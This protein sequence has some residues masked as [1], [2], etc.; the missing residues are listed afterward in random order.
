[1]TMARH[2]DVEPLISSWVRSLRADGKSPRTIESYASA[3]RDFTGWCVDNG[4]PVLP[5]RQRRGDVEDYVGHLIADRSAGT[6]GVR[7]RSLRQWFRWLVAEDEADDVMAGMRHPKLSTKVVPVIADDDLRALL[8]VTKGRELLDRRD[9]AIFR[10][11]IDTGM[12]RG[13]L[14][15]LTVG[16]VDLDRGVLVVRRSKTGAGRLVPIGAKSTA[17]IDRY[18][19]VRARH[20]DAAKPALWLGIHGPLTGEG[21]R[22]MLMKRCREAGVAQIHPHQFRHTAAHRWLMAGGQ[23]QDL[24]RMAGWAPGSVML[25]RYGASAATERALAAHRTIAPGDSL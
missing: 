18:L 1:M 4:R 11:L 22:Q 24:A 14:A 19:R 6:A 25:A 17:A 8:E 2:P 7:Y 3:V 23:E 20:R 12:R 13:E 15:G 16:D 21:V 10:V 9:H 5:D